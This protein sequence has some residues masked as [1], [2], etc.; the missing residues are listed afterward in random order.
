MA[1]GSATV[2]LDPL[3]HGARVE[4]MYRSYDYDEFLIFGHTVD[5]I[6]T[7]TGDPFTTYD[8]YQIRF[9]AQE[10]GG[11][12]YN[13]ARTPKFVGFSKVWRFTLLLTG[14]SPEPDE[15]VVG[16]AIYDDATS[17]YIIGTLIVDG[18]CYTGLQYKII[19]RME[20]GVHIFNVEPPAGYTF[21]EWQIVEYGG[22]PIG[23]SIERP[24]SVN[25]DRHIW[26]WAEVKSVLPG[27]G[28]ASI[29][30][31]NLPDKLSAGELIIGYFR[32]KNIGTVEDRIRCLVTTM[33]NGRQYAGENTV[34]VNSVLRY[35]IID[36]HDIRMPSQDAVTKIEGQHKENGVWITDDTKTH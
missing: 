3:L 6:F 22:P 32:V 30:E 4:L 21:V 20:E 17:E 28:E 16:M 33:W 24:L 1:S 25:I 8:V 5:G 18:V 2:I 35:A 19:P 15:Y 9:P 27:E 31:V 14:A 29:I 26:I 7:F 34:P 36:T 10:F 13:E 11:V 12:Q 23:T